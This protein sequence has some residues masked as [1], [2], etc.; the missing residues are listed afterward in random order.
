[1]PWKGLAAVTSLAL[2]LEKIRERTQAA[3]IRRQV[4]R[5]IWNQCF[6]WLQSGADHITPGYQHSTSQFVNL[7]LASGM[8]T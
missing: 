5:D 2:L 8:G 6:C 1:M 3:T 4:E 7:A